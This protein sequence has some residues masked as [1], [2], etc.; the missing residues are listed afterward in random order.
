M[1]FI[2]HDVDERI[3]CLCTADLA[4]RLGR[5]LAHKIVR[6]HRRDEMHGGTL[7]ADGAQAHHRPRTDDG[8]VVM[9]FFDQRIDCRRT[10]AGNYGGHL[11][12][13]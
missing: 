2:L 9:Q 12:M 10:H 8:I 3:A 1:S 4:E 5:N 13:R 7:I 6:L 11:L